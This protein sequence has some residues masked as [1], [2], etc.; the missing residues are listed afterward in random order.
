MAFLLRE[1][2]SVDV[3]HRK[4]TCCIG[5]IPMNRVDPNKEQ[6]NQH[7]DSHS[8]QAIADAFVD[9]DTQFYIDE[10]ANEVSDLC[11]DDDGSTAR[12][13]DPLSATEIARQQPPKRTREAGLTAASH[14]GE[15]VTEDD[16]S[17]ETLMAEDG[18]NS[19]DEPG[20][21]A[22]N[23]RTFKRVRAEEIGSGRGLDEAELARVDPL[24]GK[25]WD[26]GQQS[27]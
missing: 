25:A 21:G 2:F 12:I 11:F 19:P 14:P 26:G 3:V 7:A 23:D 13:G 16:L 4:E 20:Q 5:A 8:H 17:P 15:G 22:P 10:E 27:H 9:D 1:F 24:D 6:Q 18:A